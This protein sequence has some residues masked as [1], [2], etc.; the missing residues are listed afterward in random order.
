MNDPCLSL[1]HTG[2][3]KASNV[4][5]RIAEVE[6]TPQISCLQSSHEYG[7]MWKMNKRD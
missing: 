4:Y 2:K 6:R 5:T 3:G 1:T 7:R